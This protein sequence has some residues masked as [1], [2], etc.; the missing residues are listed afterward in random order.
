SRAGCAGADAVPRPLQLL[1]VRGRVRPAVPEATSPYPSC[2]TSSA[3]RQVTALAEW[4]RPTGTRLARVRV[5]P[6]ENRARVA[7]PPERCLWKVLSEPGS[8][9]FPPAR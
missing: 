9:P 3:E 1:G 7:P 6:V 2:A 8:A 5:D 4:W